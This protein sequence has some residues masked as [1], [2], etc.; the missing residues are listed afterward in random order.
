MCCGEGGT[1]QTNITG[2]CGECSQCLGHTG[3]TPLTACML[4][5]STLLSLQVALQG[6]CPKQILHFVHFS[7]LSAQVQV[8]GYSTRAQ[9]RLGVRFVPFLGLRSS[10]DQV[11]GERTVPG[12]LC[13]L[14]TSPI[15][16]SRFP[17]CATKAPSQVCCVSPLGC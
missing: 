14:I 2:M 10:G 4:S 3:F 17:G 11:L 9:N 8:L 15:P 13:I 1:L 12:G 5:Q 16:A 7:G 6:C